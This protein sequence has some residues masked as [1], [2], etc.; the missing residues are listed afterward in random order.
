[1]SKKDRLKAQSEKQ[2]RL[3]KEI[4][5][6]ERLEHQNVGESK[7]AAKLRRQ[8][9]KFD[10]AVTLIIKILMM[11]P[12]GWSAFFYG[13][14]FI[15]G[16][17]TGEM[18]GV[19][20]RIA[21]YLGAGSLLCFIGLLLAFFSKYIVQFAF[22]AAGTLSFMYGAQYIINSTQQKLADHYV[23]DAEIQVLDKTYMGYF[24]PLFSFALLSAV[25]L[26]MTIVKSIK[27]KRREQLEK[28]N[29]PVKSIVEE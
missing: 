24:Y 28:D 10:S 16:I 6:E 2:R 22:A 9:R 29:A 19:P 7:S 26:T 25:L 13:G 8:A 20:K 12:F 18:E 5:R 15:I 4:E 14:I 11:L 27:K 1:M 21:V 17:A 3:K 23:T